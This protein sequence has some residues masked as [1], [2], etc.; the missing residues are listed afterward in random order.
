MLHTLRSAGSW[1]LRARE[2]ARY[3][4]VPIDSIYSTSAF[5]VYRFGHCVR[6]KKSDIHLPEQYARERLILRDPWISIPR[7]GKLLAV[8]RAQA[9]RLCSWRGTDPPKI[10]AFPDPSSRSYV[11]YKGI[12]A[13]MPRSLRVRVEDVVAYV[14]TCELIEPVHLQLQVHSFGGSNDGQRRIHWL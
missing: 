7:V 4:H 1:F 14:E 8:S 5:P 11:Y 13:A 2:A 12:Q 9:Y 6:W 3:L 10:P